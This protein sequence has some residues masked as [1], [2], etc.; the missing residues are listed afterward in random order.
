MLI[1]ARVRVRTRREVVRRH[2]LFL[3][4]ACLGLALR[5]ITQLAYRPAL[6]FNDSYRYLSNLNFNPT[7]SQPVGYP[8]IVL[9][10]M[11]SIFGNLASIAAL[12]HALGLATGVA[13]YAVLVHRGAR[14]WVAALAATPILLDAYQLQVEQNVLAEALFQA[15]LVAGMVLLLWRPRPRP[16]MLA[17]A[18]VILGVAVTV[19]IVGLVLLPVAAGFAFVACD[20]PWR[21]RALAA[22]TLTI[23]FAAPVLTYVGYY[24]FYTGRFG[25]TTADAS[26]LAGRAQTIVDC[27]TIRLP[28]YERVLCPKE[29]RDRRLGVDQYAHDSG[30]LQ[31]LVLPPVGQTNAHVLRDFA[32]RVFERQPLDFVSAVLHDFGKG[33]AW[34]PTTSR[35]DRPASRWQFQRSYPQVQHYSADTTIRAYGGVGPSVSRPL[36]YVLRSYQLTIGFVPGPL[37]AGA[38]AVGI[39]GA[40]GLGPWRRSG[41]RAASLLPAA[42]GVLLLLG[43]AVYE[44]SWRYQLPALVLAPLG[45]AL[46]VTALGAGRPRPGEPDAVSHPVP[47]TGFA[48]SRV[49]PELRDRFDPFRASSTAP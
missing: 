31:L 37:V 21:R 12:Q 47:K 11:L 15:L 25:L 26:V 30:R 4:V 20:G 18:G 23:A 45:A 40:T 10:P 27:R 41:L 38:F 28:S 34:S 29:P 2:C 22:A 17:A 35:G 5:V 9:R 49:P 19:R 6:L 39:A 1:G 16:W 33:F 36:T 7:K 32:R 14:P 48:D 42:S 44:F 46:G 3:V 8:V 13:L 24:K 43:A